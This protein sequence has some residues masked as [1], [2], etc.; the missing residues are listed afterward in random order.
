MNSAFWRIVE[1]LEERAERA[2]A[3]LQG[4]GQGAKRTPIVLRE[5]NGGLG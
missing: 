1:R 3:A 4:D 5:E 2:E